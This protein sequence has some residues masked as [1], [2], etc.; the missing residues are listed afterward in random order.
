MCNLDSGLREDQAYQ[1]RATQGAESTRNGGAADPQ[2]RNKRTH[3]EISYLQLC[4]S[5]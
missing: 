3:M 4:D 2:T 5:D 1:F